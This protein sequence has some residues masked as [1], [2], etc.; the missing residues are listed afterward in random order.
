[1]K[2]IKRRFSGNVSENIDNAINITPLIDV[3]FVVL[4][5][6]IV[7]APLMDLERIELAQGIPQAVKK[8][9]S[10]QKAPTITI[11]KNGQIALDKREISL[12]DLESYLRN[13]YRE[14]PALTPLIVP[15]KDAPFGVYQ[16]VSNVLKKIGYGQFDVALKS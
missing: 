14:N 7:I 15:D 11:H 5:A 9:L 16:S 8:N 10:Q 4:I 6:F 13:T 1:M 12:V 3:V 2:R